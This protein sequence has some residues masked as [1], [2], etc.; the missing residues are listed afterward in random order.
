MAIVDAGSGEMSALSALHESNNLIMTLLQR[1]RKVER[2]AAAVTMS[3]EQRLKDYGE[4]PAVLYNALE[5]DGIERQADGGGLGVVEHVHPCFA[6]GVLYSN[7]KGVYI[8]DTNEKSE[9]DKDQSEEGF[10]GEK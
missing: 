4:R 9:A 1:L 6:E 5:D 2:E 7:A 8:P 3:D 10:G